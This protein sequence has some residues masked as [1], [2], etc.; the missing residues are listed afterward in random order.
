MVC[1]LLRGKK[2]TFPKLKRLRPTEVS[3]QQW[4]LDNEVIYTPSTRDQKF[5]TETSEII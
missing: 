3:G 2:K 5:F 1:F 4:E